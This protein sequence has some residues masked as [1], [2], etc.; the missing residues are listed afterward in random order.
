F[1]LPQG[2][3]T[4][5]LVGG[6]ALLASYPWLRGEPLHTYLSLFGLAPGAGL[7]VVVV[8]VVLALAGL[9]VWMGRGWG[10]PLRSARLAG[11]AAGCVALALLGA[12]PQ[13]A[14]AQ[15]C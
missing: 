5:T 7:A 13:H 9:G 8:C 6:T 10:E 12:A 3:W 15:L 14:H 1:F 2:V 4:G 11:L